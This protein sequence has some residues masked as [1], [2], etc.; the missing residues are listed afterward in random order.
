LAELAIEVEE[1]TANDASSRAMIHR[2]RARMRRT[3]LE[4]IEQVGDATRFDR[5]RHKPIGKAIDDGAK[6]VVVRPGYV[7]KG[8]AEELVISKAVVQE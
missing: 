8:S 2:I 1:L 4:P 6:V 5:E 3:G 7:W